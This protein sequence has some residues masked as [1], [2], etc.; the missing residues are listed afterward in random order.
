MRAIYHSEYKTKRDLLAGIKV[1]GNLE[2]VGQD[3]MN[4]QDYAKE[5]REELLYDLANR[6]DSGK[7]KRLT[8]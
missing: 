6:M 2:T 1:L 4:L 8:P 3:T 7:I 5:R